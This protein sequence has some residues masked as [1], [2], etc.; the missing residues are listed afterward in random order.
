MHTS[1]DIRST[2]FNQ[3]RRGYEQRD[4]DA[5]IEQVAND[6][7]TLEAEKKDLEDKLYVLAEKIEQYK[8]EEDSIKVT[9]INSRKLGESI[10]N[11]AKEKAETIIREATIKK[12]DIISSAYAEIEGSENTLAR[13]KKEVSDFKNTILHL[14]KEHI[15]SLTQLPDSDK[16]LTAPTAEPAE[17]TKPEPE[18]VATAEPVVSE[19]TQVFDPIEKNIVN[20]AVAEPKVES[21]TEII[22]SVEENPSPEEKFKNIS[23]LFEG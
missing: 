1:E 10:V 4:V 7:R 21:P 23:S 11:D 16:P 14:Y 20:E 22:P 6:M 9:L 5:F 3:S 13:L 15:E 18:T 12:N 8:A 17:E 19:P 2:T